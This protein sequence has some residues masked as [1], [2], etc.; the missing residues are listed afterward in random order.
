MKAS[1]FSASMTTEQRAALHRSVAEAYMEIF[2]TPTIESKLDILEP[3]SYVAVTCSPTKGVDVTLDVWDEM[4]HVWHAFAEM[5]PEG[6]QA[7]E[8]IASF[9]NAKIGD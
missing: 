5:L 6:E 7:C 9:V 3:G 2:P 4:F 8:Q 1:A